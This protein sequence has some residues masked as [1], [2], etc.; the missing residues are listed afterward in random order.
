MIS[1]TLVGLL[2]LGARVAV[3]FVVYDVA[4]TMLI[5]PAA[6][7]AFGPTT[8][9]ILAQLTGGLLAGAITILVGKFLY[10]TFLPVSRTP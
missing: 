6:T 10:D 3:A 2:R 4:R 7:H 9:A 1:R 8:V 5:P